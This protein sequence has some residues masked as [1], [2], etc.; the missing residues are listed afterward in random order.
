MH[1]SIWFSQELDDRTDDRKSTFDLLPRVQCALTDTV[2]LEHGLCY[3]QY[4]TS[5]EVQQQTTTRFQTGE[6]LRPNYTSRSNADA[7]HISV[8]FPQQNDGVSS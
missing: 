2:E 5:T 3:A 4:A 6:T 8:D 1:F 7:A